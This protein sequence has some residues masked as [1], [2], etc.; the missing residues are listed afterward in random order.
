M[1][2]Q[3]RTCPRV[4]ANGA[5]I[6]RF[7]GT[8][9]IQDNDKRQYLIIIS[10][11]TTWNKSSEIK[12]YWKDRKCRECACS[13]SRYCF[14]KDKILSSLQFVRAILTAPQTHGH[15]QCQQ[16]PVGING[17]LA[18]APSRSLHHPQGFLC[19]GGTACGEQQSPACV[20]HGDG[21]VKRQQEQ[22][23]LDSNTPLLSIATH[24][25]ANAN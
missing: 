11:K 9:V 7:S 20:Q 12:G 24:S 21:T 16:L 25:V 8:V 10:A 18:A 6:H 14:F 17:A 4:I 3:G 15:P 2:A 1:G 13:T 23:G 19:L 22:T 5:P